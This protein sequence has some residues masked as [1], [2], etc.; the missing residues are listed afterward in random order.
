MK[1]KCSLEEV[2][3][4][5]F[6]KFSFVNTPDVLIIHLKRFEKDG[7]NKLNKIDTKVYYSKT[8]NLKK[9]IV[10]GIVSNSDS[11]DKEQR[12]NP[13]SNEDTQYELYCVIIKTGTL[14]GGHYYSYCLSPIHNKWLCYND[15]CVTEADEEEYISNKNAYILFYRKTSLNWVVEDHNFQLSVLSDSSDDELI[16][17][18]SNEEK[19]INNMLQYEH[20]N[21]ILKSNKELFKIM[22]PNVYNTLCII[23][24][25]EK[26]NE[27][28]STDDNQ[29]IKSFYSKENFFSFYSLLYCLSYS[30]SFIDSFKEENIS[31]DDYPISYT[32]R[33]ILLFLKNDSVDESN[34]LYH[35]L[36]NYGCYFTL[37]K[38]VCLKINVNESYNEYDNLFCALVSRNTDI[39]YL[40]WSIRRCIV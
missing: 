33:S 7:S 24:G 31:F 20:L 21:M 13:S 22:Y 29:V 28:N 17:K 2:S 9:Y 8:I 15:E 32:I 10:G 11:E 12:N 4:N 23:N 27:N 14:A 34:S 3:I 39:Y 26:F 16:P 19:N 5:T 1:C 30:T 25:N 18:S 40:T 6:R 36:N 35:D 38:H 37:L